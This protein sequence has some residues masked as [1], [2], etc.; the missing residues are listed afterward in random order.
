MGRL[1]GV[2]HCVFIIFIIT[3]NLVQALGRHTVNLRKLFPLYVGAA[4]GQDR[5]STF[6]D[7]FFRD[8]CVSHCGQKGLAFDKEQGEAVSGRHLL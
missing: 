2:A 5:D 3:S 6:C 8:H 1:N 4:I 7:R